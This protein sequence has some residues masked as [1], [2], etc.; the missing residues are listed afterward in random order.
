MVGLWLEQGQKKIKIPFFGSTLVRIRSGIEKNTL[1]GR[2][3][4]RIRAK[5]EKNT[6]FCRALVRIRSKIEKNTLFGRSGKNREK[7]PFRYDF[8]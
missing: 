3:L 6:L 4:V 5:I 2:A 1:Y 8:S 7:H